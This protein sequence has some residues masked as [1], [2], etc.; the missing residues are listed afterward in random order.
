MNQVI[1]ISGC[2]GSGKST[3]AE[4]LKKIAESY[5]HEV[6]IFK[7]AQPL[8]EMHDAL[9]PILKKYNI[10]SNDIKKDGSLLQVLGTDYGRAKIHPNIWV[11]I[12]KKRI[13]QFLAMKHFSHPIAIIDDCRFENEFD[14]FP[15]A[16]HI[17]LDAPRA[18]RQQ[19]ASYWRNDEKHPSETGLDNYVAKGFYYGPTRAMFSTQYARPEVTAKAIWDGARNGFKG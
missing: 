11:D 2:Q 12:C 9:L 10:V 1:V 13:D 8:Y 14:A 19:R 4:E 5:G 3:V 15:Y 18:V 16:L 7:F 17:R 6:S